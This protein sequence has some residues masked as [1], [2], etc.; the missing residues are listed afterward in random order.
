MKLLIT[1]K[2]T[3]LLEA[4]LEVLHAQS[5]E[6]LNEVAFWKDEAAF[7]YTLIVNKTLKYVPLNAKSS[8]E[9]IEKELISI[10]GGDLDALQKEVE[11]HEVF[12]N[13]ILESTYLREE[14][15]RKRHEQLTFKFQQFEK[16]FKDLKNEVFKLVK[17]I[18]KAKLE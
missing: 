7:F 9:K 1:P 8:I 16:R 18:D 14:N 3:Y 10:T 17:Q 2:T 15:Y 5:Y 12:L 13:D 11:Q 6:W 4:G